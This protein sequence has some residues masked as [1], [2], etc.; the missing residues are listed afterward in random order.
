MGTPLSEKH[1]KADG[2]R[3]RSGTEYEFLDALGAA[4]R[5]GKPDVLVYRRTEVPDMK[6]NDPKF[7]EKKEQWDRVQEFFGEFRNPDGSYRRF[8]KEYEGPSDFKNL[9]DQPS[10][11]VASRR[12]GPARRDPLR[13]RSSP[14]GPNPPIRA[15]APLPRKRG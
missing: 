11:P 15:C 13:R 10:S 14:S 7:A 4:E 12:G 3:Y 1:H 2:S 9:L 6:M 5:T 8:C